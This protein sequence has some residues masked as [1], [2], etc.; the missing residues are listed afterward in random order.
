[1]FLDDKVIIEI[2]PEGY[3]YQEYPDQ[4]YCQIALS[5]EPND[6]YN[7]GL[8]FIR[9]YYVVLDFEFNNIR[10]ASKASGFGTLIDNSDKDHDDIPEDNGPDSERPGEEDQGSSSPRSPINKGIPRNNK[11]GKGGNN[12][13]MMIIIIVVC[14]LFVGII[15]ACCIRKRRAA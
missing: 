4:N 8:A 10:I 14:V 1:M 5:S 9:N 15:L 7:L 13:M 12:M 6:Q 11:S 3:T 2:P